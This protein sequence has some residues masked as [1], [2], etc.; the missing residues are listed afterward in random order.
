[1]NNDVAKEHVCPEVGCGKVFK[2]ASKLKKHEASHVK[3]D[4]V[5]AFCT[6]PDCLKHFTNEHYLK[7]HLNEC[8]SHINCDVCGTKQLRKNIKRHMQTHDAENSSERIKCTFD[9]CLHTFSTRSNLQQ[10]V[11]AV[12]L[13]VRPFACT[14]PGCGMRFPFKH[15]RDNHEK[16][17]Q[18]LHTNGDFEESDEI[19]RSRPRGGRKRSCPPIEA[20]LRK[21]VTP[22]NHSDSISGEGSSEYLSWLLSSEAND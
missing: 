21:R 12:H 5:E 10:H 8:H 20:L 1:M 14:M 7:I 4:S 2:Y 17:G 13:A 3:L 15:V 19:F 6:E 22:L 9:G 18:H 11:K 16:S